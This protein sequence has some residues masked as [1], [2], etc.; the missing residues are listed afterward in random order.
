M[1]LAVDGM[2]NE[3]IGR[4]L[5]TTPDT[6]RWWRRKFEDGGVA[7]VGTIAPGR[8]RKPEIGDEVI[9]AN[10]DDTLHSV[11]D[12]GSMAWT[13]R[14]IAARHGVGKD[15][16]AKLWRD[17]RLRPWQVDT[18]KLSNDPSFEAELVDVVGL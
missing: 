2:A 3:A 8:G 7:A 4:E 16:V 12:D 14:S 10:V 17:R 13:T 5:D 15:S 1:L 9:E 18:F 11:L 6:V